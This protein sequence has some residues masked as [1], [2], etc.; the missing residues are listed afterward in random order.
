ML[1]SPR[2]EKDRNSPTDGAPPLHTVIRDLAPGKYYAE[3]GYA[4]PLQLWVQAVRHR[5]RIREFA[6]PLIYTDEERSFGESLDVAAT[7]LAYYEEVLK[8]EMELQNAPCG[9]N[10]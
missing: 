1:Q 8:R 2:V 7:R 10:R 4:L 3:L 9:S 5:M 6:V